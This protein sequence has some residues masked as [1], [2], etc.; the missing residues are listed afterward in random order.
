MSENAQG[1]Q[2]TSPSGVG[3]SVENEWNEQHST[4]VAKTYFELFKHLTTLN[5]AAVAG[6]AASY[7]LTSLEFYVL[8]TMLAVFAASSVVSLLGLEKSLDTL[9]KGSSDFR[10]LN[11]LRDWE[12]P[13]LSA[14]IMSIALDASGLPEVLQSLV[15]LAAVGY[16]YFRRRKLGRQ[17]GGMNHGEET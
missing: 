6:V 12:V 9:R 13:L 16:V 8:P 10:K 5:L 2:S 14:G 7:K 17:K 15:V 4:E 3:Y 1:I 11:E